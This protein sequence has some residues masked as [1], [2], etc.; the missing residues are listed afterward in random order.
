MCYNPALTNPDGRAKAPARQAPGFFP[1]DD[2]GEQNAFPNRTSSPGPPPPAALFFEFKTRK[3]I[4]VR[5]IHV[6]PDFRLN[7]RM[8]EAVRRKKHGHCAQRGC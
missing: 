6:S 8:L 3:S 1:G 4:A 2:K 7:R 5:T